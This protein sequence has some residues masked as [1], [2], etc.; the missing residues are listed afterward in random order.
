VT[1]EATRTRDIAAEL[2]R[3]REERAALADVLTAVS[4]ATDD[5]Q[6]VFDAVITH[7]GRLC[8]ADLGTLSIREGEMSHVR[9]GW[10]VSAESLAQMQA[11]P[12]AIDDGTTA[13]RAFV[14]AKTLR[15][16]DVEKEQLSSRGQTTL[17][18]TK[19]RSVL[20]VP[21]LQAGRAIGVINLRRLT[22]RPFSDDEAAL[23]ETFAQQA[24]IA[25][26]SVRRYNEMRQ[27]LE[28]QTA[29]SAVLNVMSASPYALAP[30]LQAIVD[31]GAQLTH[32]ADCSLFRREGDAL[33]LVAQ[34]R[35]TGPL[36]PY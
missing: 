6:P 13:G 2:A 30:V 7:A 22:V 19:A 23:V 35:G 16:D 27:A 8:D 34:K 1:Q 5:A 25:I 29:T 33:R 28:R 15:W 14:A 10:N 24:L 31:A 20:C 11:E 21:L 26:E 36:L 4:R 18:L 3:A 12:Y 9:A 32:A 17:G